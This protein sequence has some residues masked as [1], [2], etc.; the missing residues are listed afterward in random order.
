MT[1]IADNDG[2]P[3]PGLLGRPACLRTCTKHFMCADIR[4]ISA[5][6]YAQQAAWRSAWAV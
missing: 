3:L 4:E 2:Y 1:C 5:L 6:T